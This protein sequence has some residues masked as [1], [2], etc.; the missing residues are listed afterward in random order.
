MKRYLTKLLSLSLAMMSVCAVHA[1]ALEFVDTSSISLAL[2]RTA[3]LTHFA[4]S[5][6]GAVDKVAEKSPEI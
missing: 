4:V 3:E 6:L 2:P 1:S 5:P